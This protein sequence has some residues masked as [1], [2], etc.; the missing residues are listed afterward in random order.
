MNNICPPKVRG[1]VAK[2]RIAFG[3]QLVNLRFHEIWLIYEGKRQIAA[4]QAVA[5]ANIQTFGLV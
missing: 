3:R 1:N 4:I 5:D 2:M